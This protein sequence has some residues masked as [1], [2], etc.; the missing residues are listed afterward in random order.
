MTNPQA[1]WWE[2]Q[3]ICDPCIFVL[4]SFYLLAVMRATVQVQPRQN[5]LKASSQPIRAGTVAHSCHPSL[6]EM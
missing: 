5:V 4:N 2:K 1:S 6:T 3:F